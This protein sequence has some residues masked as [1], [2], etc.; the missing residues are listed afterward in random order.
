MNK[1]QAAEH[2]FET[3]LINL[4][5][6]AKDAQGRAVILLHHT[7]IPPAEV[8]RYKTRHFAEQYQHNTAFIDM[9]T[10]QAH[11]LAEVAFLRNLALLANATAAAI[12]YEH[13]RDA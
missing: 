11:H 8:L 6:D 13:E 4:T 3:A 1:Q 5:Q 12:E 2:A 10:L 7:G 9:S